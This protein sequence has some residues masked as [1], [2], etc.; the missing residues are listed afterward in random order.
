M[1]EPG[2]RYTHGPGR[3]EGRVCVL[4][5]SGSWGI[6]RD[7]SLP[8]DPPK[9]FCALPHPERVGVLAA[10]YFDYQGWR[11]DAMRHGIDPDTATWLCKPSD[12]DP[13]PTGFTLYVLPSW[14]TWL[15]ADEA[16]ARIIDLNRRA[17]VWH[18]WVGGP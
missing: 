3:H 9:G 2:H 8:E 14:D 15:D 18:L 1:I 12:L 16:E 11:L 7:A 17:P 5:R 10:T 4:Q 13:F 6:D